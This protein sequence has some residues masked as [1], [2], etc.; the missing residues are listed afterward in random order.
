MDFLQFFPFCQKN[1]FC[2]EP[3]R[4]KTGQGFFNFVFTL[5]SLL[6]LKDLIPVSTINR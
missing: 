5:K 3:G 6:S 1:G 4:D 2:A